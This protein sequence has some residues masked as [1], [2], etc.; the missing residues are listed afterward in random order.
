MKLQR[1]TS[2]QSSLDSDYTSPSPLR[3]LSQ[4]TH[5]MSLSPSLSATTSGATLPAW[6]TLIESSKEGKGYRLDLSLASIKRDT[7]SEVFCFKI[8]RWSTLTG[9][10][11]EAPREKYRWWNTVTLNAEEMKWML[12]A[13]E[14]DCLPSSMSVTDDDDIQHR[15]MAIEW[16]KSKW[17]REDL[18]IIG[19]RRDKKDTK[20][21]IPKA[22]KPALMS[23]L[24]K[25]VC[26]IPSD[27]E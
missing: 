19:S 8:T 18:Q 4:T 13:L 25:A 2:H 26:F 6:K 12:D 9:K 24:K 20:V 3:S 21:F 10:K 11:S 22:A 1:V 5:T 16:K 14:M 23:G 7:G 15:A 27:F 17:G